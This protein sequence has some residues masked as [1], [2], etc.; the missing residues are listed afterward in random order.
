MSTTHN[1]VGPVPSEIDPATPATPVSPAPFKGSRK[2]WAIVGIVALSFPPLWPIGLVVGIVLLFVANRR[3][4][5][6]GIVG[7]SV[8]TVSMAITGMFYFLLLHIVP[9]QLN[10]A[11]SVV[12]VVPVTTASAP[13]QT[14]PPAV[15]PIPSISATNPVATGPVQPI[16]ATP[17][18]TIRAVEAYRIQAFMKADP[19]LL[20]YY[21]ALGR[22]PGNDRLYVKTAER[23]NK[24]KPEHLL[25]HLALSIPKIVMVKF[26]PTRMV[27]N[28]TV[29]DTVDGVVYDGSTYNWRVYEVVHGRWLEIDD[30]TMP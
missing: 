2:A 6:V 15:D 24:I 14:T 21:F 22:N 26:T 8:G 3:F 28:V 4:R 27:A 10:S 11:T 25:G 17:E 13:Q 16:A 9:M 30:R 12:P 19:S 23:I 20:A 5:T 7:V 29:H 1:E 18:D